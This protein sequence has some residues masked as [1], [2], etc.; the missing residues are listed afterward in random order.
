M[1]MKKMERI[2]Q[3]VV[4]VQNDICQ[5]KIH[6]EYPDGYNGDYEAVGFEL[7]NL[8]S[9]V[10]TPVVIFGQDVEKDILIKCTNDLE[11]FAEKY[12][13]VELNEA[14]QLLKEY[15]QNLK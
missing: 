2:V 15:Y 12:G 14:I 13:V 11:L 10:G 6:I 5:G 3:K 7:A 1:A 4:S 8:F 9:P